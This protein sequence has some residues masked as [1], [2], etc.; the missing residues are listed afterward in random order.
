MATNILTNTAT[1]TLSNFV[2][3]SYLDLVA[4]ITSL[5]LDAS[6][7]LIYPGE[8]VRLIH[9]GTSSAAVSFDK[10]AG[11]VMKDAQQAGT[12]ITMTHLYT[13]AELSDEDFSNSGLL[14]IENFGESHGGALGST[15][16]LNT[17]TYLSA[18]VAGANTQ[19]FT[20]STF[21]LDNVTALGKS[22]DD[23]KVPVTK[24]VLLLNPTLHQAL[25]KDDAVQNA[26]SFGG[27]EAIRTG[28]L[29]SIDTFS[30]VFCVTNLPSG[31]AGFALHPSCAVVALRGVQTQV[32]EMYKEYFTL[33]DERT[34]IPITIRKWGNPD[35]SV[36]RMVWET[37]FGIAAGNVAGCIRIVSVS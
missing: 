16:T 37:G 8:K 17:W 23:S 36:A 4:P 12:D 22:L 25:R 20:G 11:Y 1:T 7:S 13:A 31:T 28:F 6:P 32:P 24:R 14:T 30:K 10:S 15:V 35:L 2:M 21:S 9:V 34:Q 19:T 29:P 27:P 3:Q 33:Q 18:S 5:T 26:A